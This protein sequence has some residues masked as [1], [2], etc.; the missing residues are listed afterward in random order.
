MNLFEAKINSLC[1]VE[2]LEISDEPTKIRLMELGLVVGANVKVI[3]KS[4]LKDTLL[5][6]FNS[7]CFTLKV[8][9]ARGILVKYA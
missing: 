4:M 3:K 8:N 9:L 2:N 5:I 7:T 1:K 6:I